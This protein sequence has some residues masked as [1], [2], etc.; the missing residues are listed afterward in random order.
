MRRIIL[1]DKKKINNKNTKLLSYLLEQL[2]ATC[3][4][5]ISNTATVNLVVNTIVIIKKNVCIR[6]NMSTSSLVLQTEYIYISL[7]F[8]SLKSFQN[9]F[10]MIASHILNINVEDQLKHFREICI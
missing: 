5:I 9:T 2:Q 3:P 7:V 1:P 4:L 6:P 10:Y 8:S